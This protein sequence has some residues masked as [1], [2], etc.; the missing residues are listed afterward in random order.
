MPTKKGFLPRLGVKNKSKGASD[1]GAMG[2]GLCIKVR[3]IARG[4]KNLPPLKCP[5]FIYKN[6]FVLLYCISF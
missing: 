4:E 1:E 5:Q 2:L 3:E 6:E